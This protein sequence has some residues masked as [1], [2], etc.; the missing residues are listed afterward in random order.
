MKKILSTL[1]L[2][3]AALFFLSAQIPQAFNYQAVV[4]DAS[5]Q[6]S[7]N[8]E[9]S[10][11]ITIRQG[12]PGGNVVYKEIH[13][14]TTNE[15]GLSTLAIGAGNPVAGSFN[16]INWSLGGYYLQI[17]LDAAGGNNYNDMGT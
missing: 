11:R 16:L 9:V 14:D 3:F 15:F 6:I 13:L 8:Q 5:G 4:R 10:F 12:S 17:E 7:A 2:S 1:W